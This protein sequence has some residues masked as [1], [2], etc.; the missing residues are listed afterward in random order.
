MQG[1]HSALMEKREP[2]ARMMTKIPKVQFYMTKFSILFYE[3]IDIGLRF[4]VL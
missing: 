4:N 3:E 2:G 1:C